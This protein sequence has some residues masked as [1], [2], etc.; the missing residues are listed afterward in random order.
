MEILIKSNMFNNSYND[1][2]DCPCDC[3]DCGCD[4]DAKCSGYGMGCSQD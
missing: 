2:D 4:H 3:D 1:C